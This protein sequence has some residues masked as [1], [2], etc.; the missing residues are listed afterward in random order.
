MRSIINKMSAEQIAMAS[1]DAVPAVSARLNAEAPVNEV[2][3]GPHGNLEALLNIAVS[4][5]SLS[6]LYQ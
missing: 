1:A 2:K 6:Q 3:A 5:C 4:I